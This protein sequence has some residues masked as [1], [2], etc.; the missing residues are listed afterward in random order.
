[1]RL[2]R[3]PGGRVSVTYLW[4]AHVSHGRYGMI[5]NKSSIAMADS[6]LRRPC[7][8]ALISEPYDQGLLFG[9]SLELE[10]PGTDKNDLGKKWVLTW[11]SLG[12]SAQANTL[13]TWLFYDSCS[14]AENSAGDNASTTLSRRWLLQVTN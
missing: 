1:M 14:V 7:P 13:P 5:N 6:S 12:L 9:G 11:Q 3:R 8:S 10:P 4:G 2:V